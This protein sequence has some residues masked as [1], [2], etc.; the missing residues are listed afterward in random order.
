S[1]WKP[2][3]GNRAVTGDPGMHPGLIPSS[4][5]FL[6]NEAEHPPRAEPLTKGRPENDERVSE[7]RRYTRE[8]LIRLL[9]GWYRHCQGLCPPPATTTHL[10]AQA[11]AVQG[12]VCPGPS[13]VLLL[14]QAILAFRVARADVPPAPCAL[15]RFSLK[16]FAFGEIKPE[17]W[18][19]PGYC[20]ID[21]Q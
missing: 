3:G 9:S 6:G 1:A 8:R 18:N 17:D 14:P 12:L 4:Y 11:I 10:A 19:A 2:G 16:D 21:Q 15:M 20:P 7:A 5:A 13:P